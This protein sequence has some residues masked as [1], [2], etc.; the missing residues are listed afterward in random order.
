MS[1]MGEKG[2]ST[3]VPGLPLM[4]TSL[5]SVFFLGTDKLHPLTR[6]FGKP[7]AKETRH[8]ETKDS[9][10]HMVLSELLAMSALSGLPRRQFLF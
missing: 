6:I 10:H 5:P 2:L 1:E 8:Q 4:N 3:R 7:I 9:H